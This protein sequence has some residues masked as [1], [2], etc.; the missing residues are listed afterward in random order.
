M[1]LNF[2]G[3]VAWDKG[4]ASGFDSGNNTDFS[5]KCGNSEALIISESGKV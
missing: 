1:T 5:L 2:Q 4:N 3:I